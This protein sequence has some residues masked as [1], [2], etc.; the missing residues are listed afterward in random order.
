MIRA[1]VGHRVEPKDVQGPGP[2]FLWGALLDSSLQSPLQS[3][4]AFMAVI[5]V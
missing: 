2:V 4:E 5:T 1:A 3:S